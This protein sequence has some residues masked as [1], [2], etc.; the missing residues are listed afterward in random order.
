[1]SQEKILVVEDDA[2][3]R[4]L[5]D[6]FLTSQGYILVHAADGYEGLMLF[7]RENPSLVLMDVMMPNLDGVRTCE[8]IRKVSNVP[9]IFM[10]CKT[11]A[12]DIIEGLEAGGDDYVIKPFQM[13]EL[14]ARIRSNLRRAPIFNRTMLGTPFKPTEKPRVFVYNQ[15]K[16]DDGVQKV[17]LDGE[18]IPLSVKEYRLLLFFVQHPNETFNLQDLYTHVWRSESLGDTRTVSVHMSNLRKKIEKD[19]T[20][21]EYILTI[22]GVGFMFNGKSYEAD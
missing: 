15:L 16:V 19:P 4:E 7:E 6:L 1:M 17:Y 8:E 21:P 20:N 2:S 12:S 14:L 11:D 13:D 10:S 22:R 5:L 3:I 9:I 18:E